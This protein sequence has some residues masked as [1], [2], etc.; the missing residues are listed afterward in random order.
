VTSTKKSPFVSHSD[1]VVD[2]DVMRSKDLGTAGSAD[3][4]EEVS[5]MKA[6][7]SSVGHDR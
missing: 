5:L 4:Y 3:F 1:K 6:T 7:Q 2:L